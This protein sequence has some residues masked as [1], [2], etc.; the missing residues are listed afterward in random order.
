MLDPNIPPIHATNNFWIRTEI[1]LAFFEKYNR[2][3]RKNYISQ[4]TCGY[5]WS[6]IVQ[7]YGQLTG[8]VESTFY[9]SMNE[10]NSQYYLP[11]DMAAIKN[12]MNLKK[13]SGQMSWR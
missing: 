10:V 9:A 5:L 8:I 3:S 11:E 12:S 6:A 1:L 13:F 7:D 4:D 2:F